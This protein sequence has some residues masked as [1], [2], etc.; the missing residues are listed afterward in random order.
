MH[1]G[2]ETF[3]RRS[4]RP[5]GLADEQT[6]RRAAAL[7]GASVFFAVLLILLGLG[8]VVLAVVIVAA[9]V[10]GGVLVARRLGGGAAGM[11]AQAR[12]LRTPSAVRFQLRQALS[13]APLAARTMLVERALQRRTT[14]STGSELS[15]GLL[16]VEAA[17]CNALGLALRRRGYAKEAATLHEAA[18]LIF[19]GTGD[20]RSEALTAN[21]LGVALA[22]AGRQDAALENFTHARAVLEALGDRQWAGK[23][24]AN[25]GLSK[26]RLGQDDQAV[27]FLQSALEVLTPETEA[28]GRV[29]RRLRRTG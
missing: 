8:V 23:V 27:E 12:R 13:G 29:E 24:L 26:Q 11:P 5:H 10:A 2:D 1:A 6:L 20:S 14:R 16:G 9:C 19:A 28:Y 15:P 3:R 25:I 7:A 21:V 22:E 4:L 17:R 18:R